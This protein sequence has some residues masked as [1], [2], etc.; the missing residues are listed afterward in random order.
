MDRILLSTVAYRPPEEVFPYVRS[1]TEYPRYTEHLKDVTV[2]GDGDAGSVYD[3]RLAWWKLS[4]TAR[5]RVTD[6][7]PPESLE[8]QLVN[9]I[10][11]RGEW[12][13]E[14][15]PD[16]V[17]DGGEGRAALDGLEAGVEAETASRIYF[18]AVYDPYS[19][20]KD[21]ISLPRFVSL[22]WVV[23]KVQPRLL[24]EAETVVERLVADIEGR[25][26]PREV[27]LTVH[28]MP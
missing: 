5:S 16:A 3:L 24:R 17:P 13:V 11:A 10:D 19:A 14:P 21:A 27:E 8:W 26:E 4:Y 28:E 12:R 1:F 6:V 7:S 22:D 25:D 2:H 23:E 18:E 9:D 15:E 20:N